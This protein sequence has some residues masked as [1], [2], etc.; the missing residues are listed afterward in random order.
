MKQPWERLTEVQRNLVR[1]RWENGDS[2][3]FIAKI[4]GLTREYVQ[5]Y[6]KQLYIPRG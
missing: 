5:D 2:I 6:V 3:S 1:I 4:E